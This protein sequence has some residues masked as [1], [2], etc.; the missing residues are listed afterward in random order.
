MPINEHLNRMNGLVGT[1]SAGSW[2]QSARS[3]LIV[4]TAISLLNYLDRNIVASLVNELTQPPPSGLGLSRAQ[5]GWLSSGFVIVYLLTSPLLVGFISDLASLEKALL[6][7]P[8]AALVCSIIW[9]GSAVIGGRDRGSSA[10]E[11]R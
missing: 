10:D 6:M 2:R 4:L 8:L 5:V 1:Q 9:L 11:S 3:A 7:V